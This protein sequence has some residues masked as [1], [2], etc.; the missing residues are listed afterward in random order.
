M[1]TAKQLDMQFKGDRM[2]ILI[3]EDNP[4]ERKILEIL[5]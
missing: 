3:A 4:L 5:L 2:R 1:K